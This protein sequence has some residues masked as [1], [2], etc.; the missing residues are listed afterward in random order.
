MKLVTIALA[1][2]LM[3][4]SV[5][6]AKNPKPPVVLSPQEQLEKEVRHELLMLPLVTVF[7][8]FSFQVEGNVV[9]LTGSVTRPVLASMAVKVV[10][11]I[12]GVD[13][14]NNSIE[15]LPLS[16]SDD[17]IRLAAFRKIYGDNVLGTRYGIRAN[18][19]IRI[20]VKNGNLRL[21]GVVGN[22]GDRNIAGI[23]ANELSGVFSVVNE[24]KISKD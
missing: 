3:V 4:P 10:K 2:A 11:Q 16:P 22:E 8:D 19:P 18:P 1:A 7:D 9:T 12:P 24:L 5:V 21:T 23:R 15:V 14:V 6:P 20:I 13:Q 17:R